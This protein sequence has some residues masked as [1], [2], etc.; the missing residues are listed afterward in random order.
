MKN[1]YGVKIVGDGVLPEGHEWMFARTSSGGLLLILARSSARSA[2]VL[3]EVWA[4][5]MLM[6]TAGPAA[7]PERRML[8]VD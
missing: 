3:A 2:R 6:R 1:G 7:L 4:A 5:R 8:R